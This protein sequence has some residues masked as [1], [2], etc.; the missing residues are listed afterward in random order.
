MDFSAAAFMAGQ[1]GPTN[2]I[3]GQAIQSGTQGF[4]Q[5]LGVGAP[6]IFPAGLGGMEQ[7][8]NPFG[9]N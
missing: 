3:T 1:P 7:Y 2:P 9:N 4:M 8:K 6:T 5:P